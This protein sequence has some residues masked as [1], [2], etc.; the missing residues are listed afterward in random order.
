MT[1]AFIALGV[2]LTPPKVR[3]VK[4]KHSLARHVMIHTGEA[5]KGSSVEKCLSLNP[6]FSR[7]KDPNVPESPISKAKDIA[8][9]SSK[10][11]SS[12]STDQR[13]GEEALLL[14]GSTSSREKFA[15]L[16]SS[17]VPFIIN[18]KQE[19]DNYIK[20]EEDNNIKQEEDIHVEQDEGI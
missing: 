8:K 12:S 15:V 5:S 10:C 17:E 1:R 3:R 19:E 6:F 20:Q 18:V 7:H 14:S 9:L 16:H 4:S 2:I 13:E 11:N